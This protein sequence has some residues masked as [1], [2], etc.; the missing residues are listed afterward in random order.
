DNRMRSDFVERCKVA[1]DRDPTAAVAYTD[2]TVFGSLAGLL[3]S[4]V[5]GTLVA[6]SLGDGSSIYLWRFPDPT[7]DVL[8]NFAHSNFVHGSSMY[9]RRAF[10]QVGGYV[11]SDG[12]E[13]H[14]LFY[15]IHLAGWNLVHVPH[16]LIEY[17]QHSAAQAN[18][19]IGLQTEL[20]H[21]RK[22]YLIARAKI[23]ELHQEITAHCDRISELEA[24]VKKGSSFSTFKKLALAHLRLSLL[25]YTLT[26]GLR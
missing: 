21:F 16:P 20:A 11:H 4:K 6:E 25:G 7:A 9:R 12:P 15:R 14:N 10:D 22:E 24:L 13:D 18:T 5:G 3:A 26:L 17:R 19:V 8:A 23:Q 1:L 2:M